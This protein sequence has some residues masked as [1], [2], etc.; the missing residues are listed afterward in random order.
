MS[1][2]D[3][4]VFEVWPVN[5]KGEASGKLALAGG[6]RYDEYITKLANKEISGVGIAL[7]IERALIKAKENYNLKE[8]Q[9]EIIY[10]A[11]LGE[12]AKLKSMALFEELRRMGYS[13]RQSFYC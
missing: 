6:G 10:I 11:Q 1:Y 9:E 5:D 12:P 4:T 13:V 7:G 8:S 2:Y 3:N